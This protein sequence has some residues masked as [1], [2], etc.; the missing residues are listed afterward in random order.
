MRVRKILRR[1]D[2]VF[3]HQFCYDRPRISRIHTHCGVY[4]A[5]SI[6]KFSGCQVFICRRYHAFKHVVTAENSVLIRLYYLFNAAKKILHKADLRHILRLYVC[7]L[8]GQIVCV[9]FSIY[10]DKSFFSTA[11][12]KCKISAPF[13]LYPHG[14]KIVFIRSDDY[15]NLSGIQRRKDI[16]FIRFTELILQSYTRKENTVALFRE[17]FVNILCVYAVFCSSAVDIAFFIAD[18][19]IKRFFFCGYFKYALLNIIYCFSFRFIYLFLKRV[20]II[21]RVFIVFVAVY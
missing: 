15:H 2:F 10:G 9:H 6:F 17:F 7:K 1:F 19:Y 18:E 8:S 11:V 12:N 20:C 3:Q 4:A 5:L 16:R 13:V 21:K 14:V